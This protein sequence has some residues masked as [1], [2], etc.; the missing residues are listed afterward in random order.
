[1]TFEKAIQNKVPFITDGGL[2]T[3]FIFDYKV[4]LPHFAA[5]TTLL[6][7]MYRKML[8]KYYKQ[9]LDVAAEY[10]TGFILESPTWR[11]GKDWGER[12]NYDQE[13][14]FRI[15]QRAIHFLD[16]I[17]EDYEQQIEHIYVSGCVGPRSDG[18][19]VE[20]KMSVEEAMNYHESQI[21]AFKSAGADLIT[22]MTINYVEEALGIVLAA[23]EQN[24]PIV[25]SFTVETDGK[26]PDG[27]ALEDAIMDLD[28]STGSYPLYYMINCAH[29][30]HYFSQLSGDTKW[31]K[32]IKGSRSNASALSHA[33]LD[34]SET[35]Q[36]E[37]MHEFTDSHVLLK[38]FLPDI[39]VWGGCCGSD[40]THVESLCSSLLDE[41]RKDKKREESMFV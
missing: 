38:S 22:A 39:Q 11:A 34:A 7:P 10:N 21:T 13:E 18:Y 24:I 26:L 1:M 27:T 41:R 20:D 28:W 32:R 15:N 29:P 36:R 33:E 23:R 12:M 5:F 40:H 30:S 14:I 6:N 8:S 31:L 3:T 25:M 37:P 35:V 17:R 2:E 16:V 4:D 19:V 9:Y